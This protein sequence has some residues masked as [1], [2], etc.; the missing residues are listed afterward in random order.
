MVLAFSG[1]VAA[2]VTDARGNALT[3]QQQSSTTGVRKLIITL[4][5]TQSQTLNITLSSG[6]QIGL[7]SHKGILP[8]VAAT[9]IAPFGT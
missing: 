8:Y 5:H 3:M 7:E 9:A 1:P 2:Q 6:L 4:P